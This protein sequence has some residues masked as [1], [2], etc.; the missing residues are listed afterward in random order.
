[1]D[2]A[3]EIYEAAQRME[4]LSQ[5]LMQLITL[6]EHPSVMRQTIVLT[7]LFTQVRQS[8]QKTLAEKNINL[9]IHARAFEIVGDRD[10]LFALLTNLILNAANASAPGA[11]IMLCAEKN[12]KQVRLSVRDHG[13]GIPA[14]KVALVTEPFYRVDK[15]RSRRQGGAGLGLAICQLIA[16]AHNSKLVIKSVLGQG[17]TVSI[18]LPCRE[19]IQDE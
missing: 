19:E 4:R 5:K 16:Q 13:S 11:A 1:M 3:N 2:A 10:L 18:D 17:T 8:V 7:E 6:T 9:T 12:E 14:D 15:A